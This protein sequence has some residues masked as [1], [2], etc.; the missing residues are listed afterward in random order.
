MLR[1]LLIGLSL[2]AATAARAQ[3]GAPIVQI[4]AEALAQD[5]AEYA[6]HNKVPLA[7]AMRR[8]VAQEETVAATDEIA[9]LYRHRL[10]GIAIEHHP[11]YRIVV[12]LTGTE[13]VTAPMAGMVVS[14]DVAVGEEIRPG[15]TIAVLEAMKMEHVIA[16]PSGG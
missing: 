13:P 1:F 8:L 3:E 6:R 9:R 12:L 15:A 16:A 14:V 7:E 4:P 5:A 11:D 10:A 2:G